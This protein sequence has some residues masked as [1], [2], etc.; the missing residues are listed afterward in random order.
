[1]LDNNQACVILVKSK[2]LGIIGDNDMAK[3]GSAKSNYATVLSGKKT[4]QSQ[5]IPGRE[6]EMKQNNAGGYTFTITPFQMLE[7][8]LILG[9]DAPT[10]YASAKKM[11]VDNAANVRACLQLDGKRTVDMIVN[12]SQAGRAPKNDPALFALAVAATPNFGSAETAAYALSQLS[13]VARIGTHMFHFNEY[14]DSMRGYGRGV[15]TA[16]GNWYTERTEDSLAYQLAKY[17]QRDGWS[18]RDLVSLAHVKATDPMKSALLAWGR[19]GGLDALNEAAQNWTRS[20]KK[21]Q[22]NSHRTTDLT[23][24]EIQNQR[25]RYQNAYDLLTGSNAPKLITAYETAKKATDTSTIVKCIIDGGLTHE[26]IPT[27]FKTQP[28]VW[29]ALLQ[30]MPVTA[31]VRNLGTMSKIGL[32]KPLSAASK[33]VVSRLN[34]EAYVKKSKIH[35]LQV[36]LAQGTYGQG[37]GQRSDATW[38]V[39]PTIVDALENTFYLAFANAIPTGKATYIGMDVSGSMSWASSIIQ[40]TGITAAQAGAAM[41][42]VVA[43]TEPNYAIYA[44]S[45]GMQEIGITAKDTLKTALAKTS[46]MSAGGT[47]CAAPMLHAQKA[48]ID[49]DAFMVITDNETWAGQMQP[50]QALKQYRKHRGQDDVRLIVMG[51]VS[52]Q[53]TIADPKDPYSLDIVGFDSNV[54]ALVTD[55][56]RGSSAG[57][58]EETEE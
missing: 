33:L 37:H 36:L 50:S 57:I 14:L 40:G 28:E 42:M 49:A 52:T 27:Q 41:A 38:T 8:F 48:G 7:R 6:A 17:Q 19:F 44:F 46:R 25:A 24:A 39:V 13:K 35:P 3:A 20:V 54:P 10:Y 12:I 1:M 58:A 9:S 55:F 32:L 4:S 16:I 22:G 56:I 53:F 5:A 26:M 21:W 18:T 23:S 30:K 34:D 11:T 2:K 51:M 29:E 45:T 31:M 15:K 47:D 43:R